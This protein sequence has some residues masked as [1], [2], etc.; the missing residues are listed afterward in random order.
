MHFYLL[1]VSKRFVV[2]I[3]LIYLYDM[4]ISEWMFSLEREECFE[5]KLNKRPVMVMVRSR[6][7]EGKYKSVNSSQDPYQDLVLKHLNL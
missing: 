4:K 6:E 5:K 2:N 3:I 7:L 1:K